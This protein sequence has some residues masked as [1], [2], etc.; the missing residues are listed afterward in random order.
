MT[1][2]CKK[3]CQVIFWNWTE[4]ILFKIKY[5]T[6]LKTKKRAVKFG[7]KDSMIPQ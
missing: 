6:E 1:I 4:A 7:N 5:I 3:F 2:V